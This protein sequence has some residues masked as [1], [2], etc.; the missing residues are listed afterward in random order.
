MTIL[1]TGTATCIALTKMAIESQKAYRKLGGG[2]IV[3]I[4][5]YHQCKMIVHIRAFRAKVEAWILTSVAS[6]FEIV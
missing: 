5:F 1:E 2:A 3:R 6:H 4:N